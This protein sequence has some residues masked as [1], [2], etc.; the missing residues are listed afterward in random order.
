MEP[1]DLIQLPAM[2]LTVAAA[3][4]V[5]SRGRSRRKLGFWLFLL[6]NVL[7]TAWGVHADAYALVALQC[8]LALMNVRGE[9]RNSA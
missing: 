3:W 9:L 5:G 6:S 8:C 4:Y 2:L 7:W 1:L